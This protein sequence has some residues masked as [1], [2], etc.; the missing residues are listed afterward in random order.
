MSV[1]G[2]STFEIILCLNAQEI[3]LLQ[4]P[5]DFILSQIG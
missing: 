4:N 5:Q 1:I 3:C 2:A